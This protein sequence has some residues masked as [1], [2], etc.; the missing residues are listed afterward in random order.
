V[1][2]AAVLDHPGVSVRAMC[3]LLD[4]DRSWYYARSRRDAEEA[5]T[6]EVD[7]EVQ[8]AI[9]RIVLEFPGYGY[10][11]VTKQLQRDGWVINHSPRR[12]P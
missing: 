6:P 5:G 10:R 12:G 9:E 2:E 1:I 8:D 11:R 7:V 4:V 3:E